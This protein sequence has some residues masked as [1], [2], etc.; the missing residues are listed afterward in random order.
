MHRRLQATQVPASADATRED[1]FPD[2]ESVTLSSRLVLSAI[3]HRIRVSHDAHYLTIGQV[4]ERFG[5]SVR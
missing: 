5:V 4:R 3:P 1:R 2:L